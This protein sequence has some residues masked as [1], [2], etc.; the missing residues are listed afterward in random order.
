MSGPPFRYRKCKYALAEYYSVL[1]P[2]TGY[3]IEERF[4]HLHPNGLLELFPGFAWDGASGP[5]I[6]SPSSMRASAVHDVFC[7]LARERKIDYELWHHV[8]NNFFRTQCLGSGMWHKRA[9][10]WH[11][12][13][14]F[15]DAGN[16][17]QGADPDRNIL[18][19]P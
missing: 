9:D 4:F 3:D 19:A 7:W 5:T 16:P 15:G 18:E 13:V 17:N 14:E 1:T 8:Y 2:I 10:M 11:W 6:D 12:G